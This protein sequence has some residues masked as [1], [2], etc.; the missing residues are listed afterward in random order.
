MRYVP[1]TLVLSVLALILA[2]WPSVQAWSEQTAVHHYFT[3]LLY[4]MA[5]ALFGLQTAWWAH[6]Q[7]NAP[8]L[9]ERG[10]SS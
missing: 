1:S 4:L 6:R 2:S 8:G 10:V 3:H 9:E 7:V 5:G